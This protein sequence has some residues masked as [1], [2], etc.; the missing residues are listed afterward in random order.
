LNTLNTLSLNMH[1]G[2]QQSM[3]YTHWAA[4]GAFLLQPR[5]SAHC[6]GQHTAANRVRAHWGAQPHRRAYAAPSEGRPSQAGQREDGTWEAAEPPRPQRQT[7]GAPLA[8]FVTLS[9]DDYR[10]LKVFKVIKVWGAPL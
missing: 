6:A 10:H 1:T 2:S 7:G 5:T 4:R 8:P 9:Y 3:N